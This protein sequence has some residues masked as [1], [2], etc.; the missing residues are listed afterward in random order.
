[1][2]WVRIYAKPQMDDNGKI[3]KV[4]GAV[5]E[6]TGQKLTEQKLKAALDEKNTLLQEINHRVK[7]NLQTIIALMQLR[8]R[9]LRDPA[10]LE[11]IA[12][13][14]EQ[15]RTITVIYD[16]LF[17]SGRLSKVLMQPY[18]EILT[19]H[20]L[21]A[22]SRIHNVTLHVNANNIV[23]DAH[24]A[25]PCGLMVNE[26]VTNSL[27]YAFPPGCNRE[28]MIRI[29]LSKEKNSYTLM[30]SDNG[31]GISEA[32]DWNH[33]S[34]V[35]L[36]LINLWI[37]KQMNGTLDVSTVNGTSFTMTFPVDIDA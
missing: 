23:L 26:L 33:P 32:I 36:H 28:P 21:K 29:E 17:L 12:Q 19:T 5:R 25:M 7:N 13:L 31:V 10:S 22:F 14:Q 30:V 6:I 2:R 37:K 20:L 4:V 8:S 3:I 27:K 16:E 9:E 24:W 34:T 11:L 1:V 18:L 15:I 35:G